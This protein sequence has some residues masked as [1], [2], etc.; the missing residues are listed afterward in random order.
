MKLDKE[1]VELL[2]AYEHNEF[3][4]IRNLEKEK[5]AL[6]EAAKETLSKDRRINI[7]LTSRDLEL[8]QKKAVKVGMPYQTL[9]SSLIHKYVTEQVK[10]V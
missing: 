6:I 8:I 9:I 7:R 2:A 4:R 3:R 10:E 5:A 1:E